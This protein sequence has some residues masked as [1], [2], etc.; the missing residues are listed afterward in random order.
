MSVSGKVTRLD[1]VIGTGKGS[2]FLSDPD[3]RI[4]TY[5]GSMI[6]EVRDGDNVVLKSSL[7][8]GSL[9]NKILRNKLVYEN[10][11]SEVVLLNKSGSFYIDGVKQQPKI[12]QPG[13]R[14]CFEE[15]GYQLDLDTIKDS[16]TFTCSHELTNSVIAMALAGIFEMGMEASS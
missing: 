16:Y 1:P 11:H 9:L 10:S 3:K 14:L 15:E 2:I 4:L 7:I 5:K 13:N 12:N 8:K 6:F